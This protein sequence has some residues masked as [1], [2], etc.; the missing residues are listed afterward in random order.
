M[1]ACVV[2]VV[3]VVVVV[4]VSVCVCVCVCVSLAAVTDL[5]HRVWEGNALSPMPFVR[6]HACGL[7]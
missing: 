7:F 4:C 5:S 3:V 6:I 2:V 1:S